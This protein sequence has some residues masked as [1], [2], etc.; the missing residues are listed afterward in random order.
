[1]CV[2]FFDNLRMHVQLLLWTEM[3]FISQS[4]AFAS[5]ERGVERVAAR[6]GWLPAL[7]GGPRLVCL[8]RVLFRLLCADGAGENVTP[9]KQHDLSCVNSK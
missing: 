6:F 1:M 9:Q 2:F 3:S 7:A 8:R 5:T 4:S